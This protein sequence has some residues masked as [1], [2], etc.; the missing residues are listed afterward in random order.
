MQLDPDQSTVCFVEFSSARC[1]LACPPG[2]RAFYEL[3]I[4]T[5]CSAYQ[6]GFCQMDWT[7]VNLCDGKG[8]GDDNQSWGIDGA[9]RLK[10]HNGK[11]P[12]EMSWYRGDVVGLACDLVR[13]EVWVAVNGSWA[14]PNGKVFALKSG[15]SGLHPAF[16]SIS[17]A[18]QYNFGERAFRYGPP[19][20]DGGGAFVSFQELRSCGLKVLFE[21]GIFKVNQCDW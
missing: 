3:E 7:P 21:H 13:N 1:N 5:V 9:R 17:G 15:L 12:Y 11:A 14:A 19:S 16:T 6:F 20:D 2:R 18:V 10:W 8:V 4:L